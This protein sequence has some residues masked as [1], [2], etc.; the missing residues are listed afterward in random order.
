MVSSLRLLAIAVGLAAIVALGA[1][2][3]EWTRFGPDTDATVTRVEQDVRETV[4]ERIA[5]VESL[6]TRVATE[7]SLVGEAAGT[8]TALPRLFERLQQLAEPVDQHRVAV[9]VYVPAAT[10]GTYRVLAWSDG[11]GEKNLSAARLS[12]PATLFLAPGHAGLRLIRV[13]PITL[14]GQP[15]A[16]AVAETVLAAI[17]RSRP[18]AERRLSTRFGPV[19]VIE[20]YASARDNVTPPGGFVIETTSGTP[21]LEVRV[22]RTGLT[23]ARRQF[24]HRALAVALLPIPLA[25]GLLAGVPRSRRR[26]HVDLGHWLRW[27]TAALA[28]IAAATAGLLL[29]A[30]LAD[31]PRTADW[32]LGAFAATAVVAI[33][34]GHWWWRP[35]RPDL[36]SRA[37]LRFAAEHLGAGLILAAALEVA[38]RGLAWWITPDTL[39]R[40]QSVLFP[41]S[42]PGLVA[43]GTLLLAEIALGWTAVS[44]LAAARVRW[45]LGRSSPTLL[46]ALLLWILPTAVLLLGGQT[47]A[48]ASAAATMGAAIPAVLFALLA[49]WIRRYYR[50]TTQSMRLLLAFLAMVTPLVAFYPLSAA[51]ADRVTR[52]VIAEDYAPATARH[53]Q[54]LREELAQALR[55]VDQLP[56]LGEL[57]A[58]LP[59]N[60]TQAA[61]LI[62]NQT[63]LARS[64]VISDVELFGPDGTLRSRFAFNLPE[65]LYVTSQQT[66]QGTGCTWEGQV[67]GELTPFGAEERRMLHA[68]RGICDQS[69]RV[70]GGIV[71]HVAS[72]DDYQALP[73]VSSPSPYYD[74][75]GQPAS[76]SAEAR[77]PELGLAVYGWSQQPLFTSGQVTWPVSQ[78]TFEH[79]YRRGTPFWESIV[80]DGRRY[81]VHFSQD[82]AGIYALGYPKPTAVDHATRL[83]EIAALVAVLFV[84][85]QA[86]A[87]VYSPLA[88][89][90]HAPLHVLFHEIRTSFY[91]K[92]FLFF[93]AAA[94]VPVLIAAL[95]F[96]GYMTSRFQ[97]D[98]E[99][100]AAN[101]VAVARRVFQELLASGGRAGPSDV[102][103]TDDVMV[104]IRQVIDQDVNYFEGSELVASSQRDLF[105]S[106]LLP[107]RTPATVYRQIALDRR[108]VLVAEDRI[109]GFAYVVAAAPVP[110]RGPDAILTVPLAPRQ[111]ELTR[112]LETLNRRVLVGAVLVV[113]FAAVLGSWLAGRVADPVARLT[114]ATRQIAA[115]RLDVRIAA[116]TADELRTLINDFN[117]M[118]A[119]LVAQRA[120]LARANQL[121]AWNEM[122]RQVAHEIKNPLTPVQLAAEHL[123][124]VHTDRARPLGAVVDQCVATI[125]GQVRLLRQIASEFA[126]FAGEPASH[127]TPVAPAALLSS[128]VDPYRLGLA[129]RVTFNV[130]VPADIPAVWADRTLLSR[131]L[132]NLVENAVQAMPSGG[133]LVVRG[134]AEGSVLTLTFAD[135]GPGMDETALA[136]AFE[137]YFSTKTGGSGLGLANA[138]RN[139]ER[140]HGTI[141]I[142]S[143]PGAGTTVTVTLPLVAAPRD[144]GGAPSPS[145]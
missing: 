97:A 56:G 35:R 14:N 110:S 51:T 43:F 106:G 87:L 93:V 141:A 27:T 16:V 102:S 113:L 85:L 1:F 70:L 90:R 4:R 66:R 98:V 13:E 143:T 55:D 29:L 139:I 95:T 145:R 126:N 108:P 69:G 86:G 11:P 25:V 26:R 62:W 63:S 61:F 36:P 7:G 136:R 19:T 140:E 112:E 83:A 91:R 142:A 79:L 128:I 80:A 119:T 52:R 21:L 135:T 129:G 123:Q 88:E 67:F 47:A 32:A 134:R 138:K 6:A 46:T 68:E 96:G 114:R 2:V 105:D 42:L 131:A 49:N 20:Q 73:F 89:Q 60:D 107:T 8:T 132:T 111:R 45:R 77:L 30:R 92:L 23:D 117:G 48:S 34:P 100:E 130:D 44:M 39:E 59:P 31:L 109:G 53:P 127:P 28:L 57:V 58:N 5:E 124:Q 15:V 38:A 72:S 118:A 76:A 116:D 103:P 120:E 54:Q 121:K 81:D 94:V 144:D 78:S 18:S 12:G 33:A 3:W 10:A 50:R 65:Y 115:G 99:H 40:G 75:L 101:T 64:R 82:R 133:S 104:W 24:R 122:A 17:D 84:L 74:L 37:Q 125:L 71:V 137:P 9:T 41:F 22:D